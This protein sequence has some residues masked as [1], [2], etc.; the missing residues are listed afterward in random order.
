[1]ASTVDSKR[2]KE[3]YDEV[4]VLN[5]KLDRLAGLV[6]ASKYTV[7]FTGAGVSTS[8]GVSDY[9]GPSGAWTKRKI[10]ELQRLSRPTPEEAHEL[11]KLLAEQQKEKAKAAKKIPTTDAQPT[12]CHMAM[13]KMVN[14]GHA[15]YIVTTNLDGI[16]RKTG[17]KQEQLCF[18][19]GDIYTERC[20]GCGYDFERN[21]HVRQPGIHVHDHKVG[22]C[23]RCGSAPPA[24][25]TG[26]PTSRKTGSSSDGHKTNGLIGTQDKKVGTKDTHINFGEY[27]DDA[28][29][30]ACT[31]HCRRADL[32]IVMGTSMSLGHIT[33]F[34]FMANTTVIV[35]LQPTPHDKEADM[36]IWGT[37][38]DVMQGLF[39]RL[40]L[41]TDPIP[42]WRPR[43]PVP[44]HRL[45][46]MGVAPAYC[47]AAARLMSLADQ[48]EAELACARAPRTSAGREELV[49]A[50][51]GQAAAK[52]EMPRRATS[53]LEF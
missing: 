48:R 19:H 29:Y 36:R 28:D 5:E 14:T 49:A 16:Y 38:D 23:E 31:K 26:R 32:C 9:R 20:T 33:H 1:M 51:K 12:F 35:N 7:F 46:R 39:T 34:P 30:D 24:S 8:A 11:S 50:K 43:D 6:Q 44:L 3:F 40:G 18:L 17:L 15:G 2:V 45:K 4:D 53:S 10:A 52:R 21:Y 42:V 13:A 27:L 41:Q 47:E 25:Y 37:C 22:T